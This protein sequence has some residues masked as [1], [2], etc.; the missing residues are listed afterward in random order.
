MDSPSIAGQTGPAVLSGQS[1]M[2]ER[3]VGRNESRLRAAFF[4]ASSKVDALGHEDGPRLQ[5]TNRNRT[6]SRVI[7]RKRMTY[8]TGCRV[9][10][11]FSQRGVLND[12]I[13][14]YGGG[15]YCSPRFGYVRS[16]Y[17]TCKGRVSATIHYG[18]RRYRRQFLSVASILGV[19][20]GH[21]NNCAS[22]FLLGFNHDYVRDA[23]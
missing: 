23:L 9:G 19:T 6:A 16:Q 15:N 12:T 3:M 18:V 1:W 22:G 2:T 11:V 8:E 14:N 5:P 7:C 13:R 20:N 4:N 21:G 10:W 17:D